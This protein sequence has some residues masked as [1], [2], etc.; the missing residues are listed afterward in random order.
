MEYPNELKTGDRVTYSFSDL[1]SSQSVYARFKPQSEQWNNEDDIPNLKVLRSK[2]SFNWNVFSIPEWTRFNDIPNYLDGYAVVGF[3]IKA[4]RSKTN[5]SFKDIGIELHH[6][7]E[8]YNYSHL[9]LY[10]PKGTANSDKLAFKESLLH[11]SR[12]HL[13]PG[14]SVNERSIK[15]NI[16]LMRVRRAVFMFR[17]FF[18]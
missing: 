15:M 8:E 14:S 1:H 4:F 6:I 3:S 17:R 13:S 5:D 18:G 12:V 2:Q 10:F 11:F 7:P 9:Q 16:V